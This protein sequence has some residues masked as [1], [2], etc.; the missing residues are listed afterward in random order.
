SVGAPRDPGGIFCAHHFA[1]ATHVQCSGGAGGPSRCAQ[2]R[3]IDRREPPD[4]WHW[5]D[6]GGL[7]L[8]HRAAGALMHS[9]IWPR[10]VPVLGLCEEWAGADPGTFGG[11][12]AS[13]PGVLA[14]LNLQR[15]T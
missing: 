6:A 10:T 4:V 5:G 1:Y 2:D 12:A 14:P 7:G 13:P 11:C 15:S 9:C 3:R 8:I